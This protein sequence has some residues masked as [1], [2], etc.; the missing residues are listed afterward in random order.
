MHLDSELSLCQVETTTPVRD[1]AEH[2]DRLLAGMLKYR[3]VPS[4]TKA[5]SARCSTESVISRLIQA[6]LMVLWGILASITS[7][8]TAIG[9]SSVLLVV[10]PVLL[11]RRTHMCER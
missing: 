4:S 8:H 2:Y 10:T 6:A 7:P 11:P 3:A 9:I 1:S 5:K